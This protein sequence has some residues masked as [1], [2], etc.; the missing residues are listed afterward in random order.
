MYSASPTSHCRRISGLLWA[1]KATEAIP[2][3]SE[4]KLANRQAC[5]RR[6]ISYQRKVRKVLER[7]NAGLK[8]PGEFHYEQLLSFCD[9]NGAGWARPDIFIVWEDLILLIEVKLTQTEA[10]QEQLLGLYYPLLKMIYQDRTIVMVQACHNLRTKPR[11]KIA[12][13]GE[14]VAE[15]RR[16]I[17]TWHY[18]G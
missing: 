15:P 6:G 2:A 5:V 17:W 4:G 12:H 13:P 3:L 10:A 8:T 18:L 14:L 1:M 7:W 11:R 16:G 9:D